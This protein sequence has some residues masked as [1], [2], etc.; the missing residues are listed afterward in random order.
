MVV[1]WQLGRQKTR[2]PIIDSVRGLG[3]PAEHNKKGI[4]QQ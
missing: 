4:R 2:L 3:R 1:L